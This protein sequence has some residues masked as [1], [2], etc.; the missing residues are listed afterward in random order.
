MT[1]KR[2]EIRIYQNDG[3]YI[4]REMNDNEFSQYQLDKTNSEAAIA[5]QEAKLTTKAAVLDRLGLTEEEAAA[6]LA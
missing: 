1:T 5:A 4:D 3:S 6:L 2:P